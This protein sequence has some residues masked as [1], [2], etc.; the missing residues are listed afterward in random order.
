MVLMI[1]VYIY[2]SLLS[3]ISVFLI[4]I[5]K[6]LQIDKKKVVKMIDRVQQTLP[7]S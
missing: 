5:L 1:L 3:M 6:E 4:V 2:F 7:P